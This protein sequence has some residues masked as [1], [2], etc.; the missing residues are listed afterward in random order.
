MRKSRKLQ[1]T[2]KATYPVFTPK[3]RLLILAIREALKTPLRPIAPRPPAKEDKTAAAKASSQPPCSTESL[4][5]DSEPEGLQSPSDCPDRAMWVAV[6][7]LAILDVKRKDEAIR[8]DAL[9]FFQSANFL[10]VLDYAGID[11]DLAPRIRAKVRSLKP[12]PA[13]AYALAA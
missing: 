9:A 4:K 1:R 2:Q 11:R 12:K 5:E 7:K 3:P 6:L 10:K 8:R 13:R